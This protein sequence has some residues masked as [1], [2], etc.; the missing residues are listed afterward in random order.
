MGL[1]GIVTG[2][3]LGEVRTRTMAVHKL[4]VCFGARPLLSAERSAQISLKEAQ[5]NNRKEEK[6]CY[7]SRNYYYMATMEDAIIIRLDIYRRLGGCKKICKEL[8]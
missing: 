3:V 4:S 6:Q 7:F 8:R 5:K 1:R 2:A